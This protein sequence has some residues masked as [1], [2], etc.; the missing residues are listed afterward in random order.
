MYLK[1]KYKMNLHFYC[2]T[3]IFDLAAVKLKFSAAQ[4]EAQMEYKVL[5]IP[6]TLC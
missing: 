5:Y 3:S 2:E 6:S 4:I 1:T